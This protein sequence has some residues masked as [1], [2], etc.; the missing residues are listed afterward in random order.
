M[1]DQRRVRAELTQGLHQFLMSIYHSYQETLSHE[2]A[3]N[4]I[5][6]KLKEEYTFFTK[7]EI[8]PKNNGVDISEFISKVNELMKEEHD[9]ERQYQMHQDLETL[10]S[11]KDILKRY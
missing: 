1:S 7:E 9:P 5:G 10:L 8:N 2:D 6:E 11:V 3:V 4:I